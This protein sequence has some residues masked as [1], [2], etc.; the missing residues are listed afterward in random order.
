V[1]AVER[2]RQDIVTLKQTTG[3]LAVELQQAYSDYLNALGQA[4]RQ[5]LILSGYQVCT[6]G[7][8][9]QFLSLSLGQREALQRSLRELATQTQANLRA[10]LSPSE[11]EASNSTD[12]SQ[13]PAEVSSP[14]VEAIKQSEL[15][16]SL[17][18]IEL[19][20]WQDEIETGIMREFR[21]V[22]FKANRLLQ[23]AGILPNKLPEFLK[24][25]SD[26]AREPDENS[27]KVL[28]LLTD[29]QNNLSS[30]D[31]DDERT[32]PLAMIVQLVAV[33]L[34]L[35]D[36]EFADGTTTVL[37]NRLR[38]LAARLKTLKQNYLKKEREL[39]IAS[40][41]DAWRAS[42]SDD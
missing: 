12:A 39:A 6:Q 41:Q 1:A 29:V 14:L 38:S 18:P 16:G 25:T 33:H 7:Y 34:Q 35:T 8:P 22:S 3:D 19:S 32:S 26:S 5:Q 20:N 15:I 28:D 2:I 31:E 10:L 42:W 23:Q 24:A 27:A 17:S 40:A 4:L 37:R 30:D 11:P 9:T 13:P 36:V 21:V